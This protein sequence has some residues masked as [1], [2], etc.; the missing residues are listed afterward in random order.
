MPDDTANRAVDMT[1]D[2]RKAAETV[3][4]GGTIKT[5]KTVFAP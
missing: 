3:F 2:L 5:A 4:C 1:A